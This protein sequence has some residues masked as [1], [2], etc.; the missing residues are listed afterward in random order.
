M[1]IGESAK[2]LAG[3]NEASTLGQLGIPADHR[4]LLL[5]FQDLALLLAPDYL[6]STHIYTRGYGQFPRLIHRWG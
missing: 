2:R 5:L 4:P 1:M 6:F 3:R